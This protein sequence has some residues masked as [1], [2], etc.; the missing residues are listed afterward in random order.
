M[1]ALLRSLI[2][3]A[4]I[5]ILGG[6]NASAEVTSTPLAA[7]LI[8]GKCL[9]FRNAPEAFKMTAEDLVTKVYGVVDNDL[10]QEQ[11]IE[12]IDMLHLS[13]SIDDSRLWLDSTEGYR[14]T[15]CG[16]TP[17][18]SAYA[19]F[20]ENAVSNYSFFFMFPYNSSINKESANGSQCEFCSTLLHELSA[21]GADMRA[22]DSSDVLFSA[23]GSYGTSNL[24]VSLVDDD[25]ADN[26]GQYILI[27]EVEPNAFTAAD[28]LPAIDNMMAAN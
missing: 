17:E 6:F 26:S 27:L 28:E 1:N 8:D 13:P 2:L 9:T 16:M 4:I 19:T 22:D 23:A 21:L 7:A 5:S 20:E 25:I 24:N 15:Y 12:C 14:V 11:V 18:V 3:I 10:S